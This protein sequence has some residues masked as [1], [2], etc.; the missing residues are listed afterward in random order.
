MTPSKKTICAY[1]QELAKQEPDKR[2]LG[3]PAGWM[4]CSQ[5]WNQTQSIA[6]QLHAQGLR[7]QDVV[8]LQTKRCLETVLVIFAL[9]LLGTTVVLVDP[10]NE[11]EQVLQDCETPI[12]ARGVLR[13]SQDNQLSL[14]I[15]SKTVL[16]RLS[17]ELSAASALCERPCPEPWLCDIHLRLHREAE[18]SDALRL[19]C[20]E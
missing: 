10:H 12:S 7:P 8:A 13:F 15:D 6:L 3:N 18:S 4:T 17:A 14:S 2:L 5:V 16:I 19:Q 20:G 1:L 9:R 11:P